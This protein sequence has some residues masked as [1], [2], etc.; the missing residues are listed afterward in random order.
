MH[1]PQYFPLSKRICIYILL[2]ITKE[3]YAK[4]CNVNYARVLK[5]KEGSSLL[6]LISKNATNPYISKITDEIL[7]ELSEDVQE[8][9]YLD[10]L[11]NNISHNMN[12]DYTNSIVVKQ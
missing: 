4:L 8:S 9:I 5:V 12:E 3:K 1:I 10:I 11:A 6:S 7:N 2:G